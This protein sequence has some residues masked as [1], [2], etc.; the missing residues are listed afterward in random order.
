M[1]DAGG[2][3]VSGA[4]VSLHWSHAE[5]EVQ[6][7][8]ARNTVTDAAGRFAFSELG[9]GEHTISASSESHVQSQATYDVG[10]GAAP[11]VLRL[12]GRGGA[13]RGRRTTTP[14]EE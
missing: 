11:P 14:D 3:A 10:S 1:L 2:A 8:S 7:S 6:S 9:K 13:P 12:Q 5:G 4:R